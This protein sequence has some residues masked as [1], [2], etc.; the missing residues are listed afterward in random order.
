ME[1]RSLPLYLPAEAQAELD[2]AR[3]GANQHDK[4]FIEQLVAGYRW[5]VFALN[6]LQ[7]YGYWGR[8]C[9]LRVRPDR[10]SAHSYSDDFDI[11]VGGYDGWVREI[12][13]KARSQPFSDPSSFP[14]ETV[15][16]EPITRFNGR[17]GAYPDWWCVVSTVTEELMFTEACHMD[18]WATES[19]LG[20]EY[21]SAPRENFLSLQQFCD[22]LPP[23]GSPA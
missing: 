17:E 3:D 11:L 4:R 7:A 5:Q 13:V 14:F 19:A 20:R 15:L 9:P 21:R 10:A 18:Q 23:I 12:E 2:V 22:A 8:I 16:M 1:G 6:A